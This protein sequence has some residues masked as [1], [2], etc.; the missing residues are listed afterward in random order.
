MIVTE[1]LMEN[2]KR[3]FWVKL[4][5]PL[6]VK[7]HDEE[8]GRE[9]H[10]EQILF[11]QFILETFQ[12]GLSWEGILN[13]RENFRTAYDGFDIDRICAYGE[14]KINSLMENPG[15]I[16][17][18]RKIEASITNT[19]IF[20]QIQQEWGSFDAYIWHF[21]GGKVVYETDKT[22]SPLSDAVSADMKKRG[23]K[24]VGSVTIYSYLQSVGIINSHSPGCFL[25]SGCNE[26]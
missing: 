1:A 2:K 16:R 11:E 10:D 8:W 13:K 6:Y 18:R 26:K 22:A 9:C 3:C 12:A 19:R 24:F 17:N 7:Y 14:E 25:Y 23:M 21:S 15:I 4:S 5:N 20:R